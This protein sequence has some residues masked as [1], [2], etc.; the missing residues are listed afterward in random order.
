LVVKLTDVSSRPIE[1]VP[2]V[3]QFKSDVPDA[4]VDPTVAATDSAG[5]AFAEVRLGTSTGS[6]QV[7]ARV[8]SV[9]QLSATFVVTAVER[10][11]GKKDN[12]GPGDWYGG[13]DD[14]DDDDE[15]DDD[16]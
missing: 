1:G 13:D 4:E 7:E 11:R 16:D 9:T 8:A 3:F 6:Q 10:E 2:V 12:D 5:L 15:D 14:D